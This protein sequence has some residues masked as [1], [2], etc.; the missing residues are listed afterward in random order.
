MD[1]YGAGIRPITEGTCHYSSLHCPVH[2]RLAANIDLTCCTLAKKLHKTTSFDEKLSHQLIPR[3]SSS[4]T[5]TSLSAGDLHSRTRRKSGG[6]MPPSKPLPPPSQTTSSSSTPSSPTVAPLEPQKSSP[7]GRTSPRKREAVR[8]AHYGLSPLSLD[9]HRDEEEMRL[10]GSDE[11]P[12]PSSG[13]VVGQPNSSEDNDSKPREKLPP[14]PG[15]FMTP[16]W[17]PQ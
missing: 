3:S 4:N 7:T 14:K 17:F 12:I 15:T 2:K 16:I 1:D 11:R 9:K 13:W 6:H 10:S 5:A 8:S